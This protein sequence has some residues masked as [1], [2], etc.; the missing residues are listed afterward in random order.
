MAAAGCTGLAK[1]K[2]LDLS[3]GSAAVSLLLHLS[4]PCLVTPCWCQA[5]GPIPTPPPP[6]GTPLCSPAGRPLLHRSCW[7]LGPQ[8]PMPVLP[9]PPAAGTATTSTGL[10]L[11]RGHPPLLDAHSSLSCP[12]WVPP[13]WHHGH[14]ARDGSPRS[15]RM[16]HP[17]SPGS[18]SHSTGPW[19]PGRGGATKAGPSSGGHGLHLGSS[20][21]LPGRGG[22]GSHLLGPN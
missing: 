20:V 2:Y 18:L 12:C 9:V 21:H 10:H 22:V 17:E 5:W 13:G 16:T 8:A 1:L 7:P 14:R 3:L 6:L 4:T 15:S 11:D 19:E